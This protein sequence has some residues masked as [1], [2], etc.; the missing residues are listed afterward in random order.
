MKKLT[1]EE[2]YDAAVK[3][4]PVANCNQV[5]RAIGDILG[6]NE[7]SAQV[8]YVKDT[9]STYE[10]GINVYGELFKAWLN[11]DCEHVG[12]AEYDKPVDE[13]EEMS[14]KD[15]ASYNA[16]LKAAT[17]IANQ[18][19][20]SG[21]AGKAMDKITGGAGSAAVQAVKQAGQVA[22][23]TLQKKNQQMMQSLGN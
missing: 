8:I 16:A 10:I 22:V 6:G 14:D 2:A 1:L 5:K 21:I 19:Q 23:K 4:K 9:G 20:Q 17:N 13:D 3:A 7:T 18:Y 15:T 12:T 11:I